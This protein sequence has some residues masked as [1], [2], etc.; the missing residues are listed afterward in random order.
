MANKKFWLGIPVL[1][2]VFAVAAIGC[3][4]GL[5]SGGNSSN[6]SG[7]TNGSSGSNDNNSTSSSNDI[8][9]VCLGDSLTAGRGATTPGEDDKSKSY[10]AYLEKKV[11]ARV[12]NAGVSSDTTAKGLARVDSNVLSHNPE[13]VI[14]LLGAND[15]ILGD[16]RL[17]IPVPASTSVKTTKANL[18]KIIDKVD[19]GNRKIFLVKFYTEAMVK[20]LPFSLFP[21]YIKGYDDMFTELAKSSANVTLIKDIWTG[22]WG[23]HMSDN[24]HPNA[25]G[26]EIMADHIYNALKPYLQEL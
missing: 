17:P 6:G 20:E 21:S 13:I 15:F 2:L 4:N 14:I 1:V 5:T 26:Y 22:V 8:T 24:I 12:V 16:D 10:P 3:D 9:L 23:V 18:Q 19:N 11:N 25:R 7:G